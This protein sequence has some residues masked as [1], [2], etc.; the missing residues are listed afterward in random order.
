MKKINFIKLLWIIALCLF[1]FISCGKNEVENTGGNENTNAKGRIIIN[2]ES[3]GFLSKNWNENNKYPEWYAGHYDHGVKSTY[4]FTERS[5]YEIDASFKNANAVEYKKYSY[6]KLNSTLH[7]I[8]N[9]YNTEEYAETVKGGNINAMDNAAEIYLYE[10]STQFDKI[11][12]ELEKKYG[13]IIKV[14]KTDS[15]Y[16]SW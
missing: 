13:D 11:K 10:K 2:E 15:Y 3:F 7:E 5:D 12:N 14:E 4:Y 16:T 1:V 6:N 8:E 9:K